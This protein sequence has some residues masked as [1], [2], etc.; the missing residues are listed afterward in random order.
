MDRMPLLGQTSMHVRLR[1]LG[2]SFLVLIFA[3]KSCASH[4][5]TVDVQGGPGCWE[6]CLLFV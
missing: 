4:F 5:Y 1:F 3:M 2:F 6:D